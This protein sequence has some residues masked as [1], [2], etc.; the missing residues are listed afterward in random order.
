MCV[1]VSAYES[2]QER[3]PQRVRYHNALARPFANATLMLMRESQR[4]TLM[5]MRCYANA[6]GWAAPCGT[7]AHTHAVL[8][9]GTMQAYYAALEREARSKKELEKAPPPIDLLYVESGMC[10]RAPE[11]RLSRL[12]PP[13]RQAKSAA[14]EQTRTNRN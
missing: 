8:V 11:T 3:L 6:Y 9:H 14:V 1:C 10:R 4:E 2:N 7:H 5:S 12:T 13:S